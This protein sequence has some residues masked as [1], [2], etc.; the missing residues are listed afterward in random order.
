MCLQHRGPFWQISQESFFHGWI[1]STNFALNYFQT[2]RKNASSKSFKLTW[3]EACCISLIVASESFFNGQD[4]TMKPSNTKFVSASSRVMSLI[5]KILLQITEVTS[6][7]N[8]AINLAILKHLFEIPIYRF[9]KDISGFWP[10]YAF[11]GSCC[12]IEQ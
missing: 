8:T 7:C 11:F 2:W 4:N 10:Y 5:W 3:C 9:C 1:T 6:T 12:W